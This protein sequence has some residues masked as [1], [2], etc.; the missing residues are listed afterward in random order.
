MCLEE[1]GKKNH[2]WL[3]LAPFGADTDI[4]TGIGKPFQDFL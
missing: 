3:S 4:D 2:R 1:D